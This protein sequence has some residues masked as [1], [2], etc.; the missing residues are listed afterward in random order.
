MTQIAISAQIDAYFSVPTVGAHLN[1]KI[2]CKECKYAS[3]WA[4]I[5]IWVISQPKLDG[6]CF[7]LAHFKGQ[8]T[9]IWNHGPDHGQDFGTGYNLGTAWPVRTVTAANPG[10]SPMAS[11]VEHYKNAL[12]NIYG[13]HCTWD[14]TRKGGWSSPYEAEIS[15][16]SWLGSKCP[17]CRGSGSARCCRRRRRRASSAECGRRGRGTGQT[18]RPPQLLWNR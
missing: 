7:N 17:P 9:Y 16:I 11:A 5:Q 18:P 12:Q 10:I 15:Y 4:D 2:I 1:H 14:L 6:F 13:T 3:I 8:K